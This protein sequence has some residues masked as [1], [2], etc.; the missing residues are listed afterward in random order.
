MF[1]DNIRILFTKNISETVTLI[2][3]IAIKMVDNPKKFINISNEVNNTTI[4]SSLMSQSS[5]DALG[6]TDFI[7]LKKKK[8]SQSQGVLLKSVKKNAKLVFPNLICTLKNYQLIL[9]F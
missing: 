8:K 1:R 9:I 6:Y 7:K 3:S 4:D 5:K 2:L